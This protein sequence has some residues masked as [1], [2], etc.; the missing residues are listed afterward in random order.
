MPIDY[1]WIP[2]EKS[3][4]Y[5]RFKVAKFSEVHER[6]QDAMHKAEKVR[7][8]LAGADVVGHVT[9]VHTTVGAGDVE[10][11][12][13]VLSEEEDPKRPR[14]FT[15]RSGAEIDYANPAVGNWTLGDLIDGI[16][17]EPRYAGQTRPIITV[18]A[19]SVLAVRIAKRPDVHVEGGTERWIAA[20]DLSE[21][22][23]H[24]LPGGLKDILPG[25]RALE[26]KWQAE[27][28]RRLFGERAKDAVPHYAI[29]KCDRLALLAEMAYLEHPLLQVANGAV[30]WVE[31]IK[32]EIH[33]CQDEL[34]DLA[35]MVDEVLE[36]DTDQ[37]R[38]ELAAALLSWDGA[39]S[40]CR[41]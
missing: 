16:A 21:G 34:A 9:D 11:E 28:Y 1:P 24:D 33:C 2:R 17:V 3:A 14:R 5:F 35:A 30:E 39:W 12:F 20:H 19:H 29:R 36:L 25:Y 32:Q 13:V 27:I 7:L 18:L 41:P 23:L 8:Q 38:N 40:G 31:G 37:L 4:M 15:S 26:E 6:L 22:L 10:V